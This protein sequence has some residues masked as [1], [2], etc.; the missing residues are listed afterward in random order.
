M[1]IFTN[2]LWKNI[3]NK[4]RLYFLGWIIF[5]MQNSNGTY[6]GSIW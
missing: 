3:E 2:Q 1:G 5:V 6:I 4:G